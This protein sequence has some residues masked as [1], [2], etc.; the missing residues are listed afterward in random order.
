[1]YRVVP[2]SIS[3]FHRIESDR[4][5]CF[6]G[7]AKRQHSAHAPITGVACN[8]NFIFSQIFVVNYHKALTTDHKCFDPF[9]SSLMV[10]IPCREVPLGLLCHQW[11]EDSREVSQLRQEICDVPYK[12]KVGVHIGGR[13]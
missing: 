13:L 7:W 1:M 5:C 10:G 6:P 2:L 9:K 3:E 12:S 11:C 8:K 4:L